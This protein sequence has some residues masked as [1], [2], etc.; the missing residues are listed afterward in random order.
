MLARL[1]RDRLIR[2][3]V[4][5]AALAVA[6]ILWVMDELELDP[7]TLL[8]YLGGSALL[9]LAVAAPAVLVVVLVKWFRR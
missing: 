6:A 7:E 5:A 9:V 1:W 4:L 8:G 2:R 3:T